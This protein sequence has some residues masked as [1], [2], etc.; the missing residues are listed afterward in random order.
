MEPSV[1]SRVPTNEECVST[2]AQDTV[3]IQPADGWS[4]LRLGEVWKA[5]ELLYFLAWRDVKVRYTQAALGVAWA[6]LQ[7]LLMMAV[8]AVFLGRLAKVPSDGVPYP[9]FSLAGLLLWTFFS[10]AL[11]SATQS[12]VNSANLVSKVWFPRLVLPLGSMLAWLPDVAIGSVLLFGLMLVYGIAPPL[13]ALAL[14]LFVFAA[15]STAASVGVWLSALNVAYR[16]IRY[17]MPFVLQLWLFATPVAYPA[18]LVPERYRFVLG[19]NPMTGVVEGFRWALLGQRPP[20]WG[21]MGVSAVVV[22]AVLLSGLY[23]FRRVE[24]EFADVI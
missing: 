19:L 17:A 6:V 18:S 5:R 24:H 9:V 13:T 1:I 2:H 16:D 21:L 23:Y 14:P 3:V 11:G 20:P 10:N 15:L 22:A 4:A 12:L 8:F 7:P